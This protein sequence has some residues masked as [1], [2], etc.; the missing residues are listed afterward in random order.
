MCIDRSFFLFYSVELALN[1]AL[2]M[3]CRISF[4]YFMS[5]ESVVNFCANAVQKSK[6]VKQSES[7]S[8]VLKINGTRNSSLLASFQYIGINDCKC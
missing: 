2:F 1:L 4:C 8:L 3:S 6:T 5:G 7:F